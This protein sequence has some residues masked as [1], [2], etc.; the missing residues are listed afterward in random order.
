MLSKTTSV[1]L[2]AGFALLASAV[3]RPVIPRWLNEDVYGYGYQMKLWWNGTYSYEAYLEQSWDFDYNCA[4][5]TALSYADSSLWA[6]S[7]YCNGYS[8]SYDTFYKKC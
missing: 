5:S 6:E 1:F 8:Q 3:T 7:I 4:R 2:I